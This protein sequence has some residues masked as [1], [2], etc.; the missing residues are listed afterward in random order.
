VNKTNRWQTIIAACCLQV[1]VLHAQNIEPPKIS[2]V[3]K[4]N[5][6]MVNGQIALT[7]FTVAI[8][9]AL[10]LSQSISIQGNQF[11]GFR[12]NY[13]G[14]GR[15]MI[16]SD[17]PYYVPR[18]IYRIYDFEDTVDFA[19]T[20]NG[21]IQPGGR[22]NYG[23]GLTSGYTYTSL[24][25]TR[26]IL[27]WDQEFLYWTKPNGT[28]SRFD[29]GY[30]PDATTGATLRDVTYPN[31]FIITA[32]GMQATTN[33][34]F[35]I[36]AMFEDDQRDFRTTGDAAL[37]VPAKADI[38][39]LRNVDPFFTST[40]SG[41]SNSR[42]R[43]VKAINNSV[44]FCGGNGRDCVLTKKWPTAIFNYPPGMPRTLSIGN[45]TM[46]IT[47]M[48]GKTTWYDFKAYDLAYVES[49]QNG[50]I[51]TGKHLREEMSPRLVGVRSNGSDRKMQYDYV[52]VYVAQDSVSTTWD[53]RL[54]DSGQ[55]TMAKLL[56]T[57]QT[58]YAFNQ[59]FYTDARNHAYGAGGVER[60]HVK[61]HSIQ[62]NPGAIYEV[63]SDA[64][65]LLREN[66]VT[67]NF[68]VEFRPLHGPSQN[69]EYGTRSNLTKIYFRKGQADETIIQAQF[70]Q[71]CTPATRKICNQAEWIKDAMGNVTS[72]TYHAPSGGVQTVTSPPNKNNIS[73]QVR[74]EY[75]QK[76][77]R[78]YRGGPGKVDGSLIWMKVSERSCAN[79][80][81]TDSTPADGNPLNGACQA[82]DETVTRYEYNH[83][84]LFLTGMTVTALNE[85]GQL[86][87]LR[88]CFKYDI[89]GNQ[90]GKTPP[91]AGLASCP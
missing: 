55:V 22:D 84:N 10:G 40:A 39:T 63:V 86:Q 7:Q 21:V 44:E 17:D 64:G 47:D 23:Y 49:E 88:S 18:E 31:G 43:Y 91:K 19:Y 89:Y 25:D 6:N 16:L 83:D 35:Q 15:N 33:T 11:L 90:I 45:T 1:A 77:A 26:H 80:N 66:T 5:V 52:N 29:R 30:N 87:T 82:N 27:E 65:I 75:A 42:P 2:V 37:G 41:W 3:D 78:Y 24:G 68:P 56:D 48:T 62:G 20:V 14:D 53:L 79:S 51:A 59:P 13:Y 4:N 54:R 32:G 36:K 9:G 73:A 81:Y 57:V 85:Q 8:G 38:T 67:R 70:P 12:A 71:T 61:G 34:G 72:Y 50:V 69:Y 58:G 60:V 74:Y 76:A 46:S 28:I